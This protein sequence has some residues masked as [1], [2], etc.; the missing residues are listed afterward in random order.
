LGRAG[1]KRYG[2]HLTR[3]VGVSPDEE[4]LFRAAVNNPPPSPLSPPEPTSKIETPKKRTLAAGRSGDNDDNDDEAVT[5]LAQLEAAVAAL[6]GSDGF[7]FLSPLSPGSPGGGAIFAE[8]YDA[9]EG[10]TSAQKP[11]TSRCFCCRP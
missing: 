6:G 9:G 4:A 1:L 5:S 11:P 10:A 3:D 2:S 8:E 7:D